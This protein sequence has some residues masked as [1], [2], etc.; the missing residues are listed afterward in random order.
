MTQAAS[1][2][3]AKKNKETIFELPLYLGA[4]CISHIMQIICTSFQFC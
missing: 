2:L 4:E 3:T 1:V